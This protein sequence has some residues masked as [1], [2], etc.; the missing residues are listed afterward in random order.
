M[1]EID[2]TID[3][4]GRYSI[5][6]VIYGECVLSTPYVDPLSARYA[7]L[8]DRAEAVVLALNRMTEST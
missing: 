3:T 2:E 4:D 5:G 6:L 1:F 7:V 8:R